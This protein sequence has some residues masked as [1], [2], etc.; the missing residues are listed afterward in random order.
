[1]ADLD[2]KTTIPIIDARRTL[3]IGLGT[4]G[5][6]ACNQILE[7]L[8]WSYE[9][10]DNVPWLRCLILETAPISNEKLPMLHTYSD[11]LPLQIDKSAYY[12][13]IQNP[14]NFDARIGFSSWNIP[15]L[16]NTGD[17]II[18]GA[19]N[20]R[21]LGRLAMLYPNNYN[22]L[23]NHL[24]SSLAA[25]QQVEERA[26][27][28]KFSLGIGEQTR[29]TLNSALYVYVIGSL[30]GGTSSGGFI[31]LGYILQGL[32]GYNSDLRTTGIFLL[33]SLQETNSQWKGNTYAALTELNHF[34]S[35]KSRYSQQ[36]PDRSAP[37]QLP[38]GTRPYEYCYLVQA[39]GAG[40]EEYAR[41]VTTS[42]DYIH[43]D[44]IGGNANERDAARTNIS[45]L[46]VQRDTWGATQKYFT[47]GLS[48]IEFPFSKVMKACSIK[49]T[50]T[51]FLAL[52]GGEKLNQFD[53]QDVLTKT[54]LLNPDNLV[55]SL[56]QRND[57][58]LQEQI[59]KV[60]EAEINLTSLESSDLAG[61]QA[62]IAFLNDQETD[63]AH[64]DL[65]IG[66]VKRTITNNARGV[67][68]LLQTDISNLVTQS[69]I[70]INRSVPSLKSILDALSEKLENG[71]KT[72]EN[73]KEQQT[74]PILKE[75]AEGSFENAVQAEKSLFFRGRKVHDKLQE[76][77]ERRKEYYAG[78]LQRECAPKGA[79]IYRDVKRY[80]DRIISRINNT[81]CGLLHELDQILE[82]LEALFKRTNVM[83]EAD[84]SGAGR[85]IRG[86][87]L[88]DPLKTV[89]QEYDNCLRVEAQKETS[90]DIRDTEKQ[91]AG[92]TL[93]SWISIAVDSLLTDTVV[94]NRYDP[95]AGETKKLD[96]AGIMELVRPARSY[97]AELKTSTIID[98][99]IND[100]S[101]ETYLKQANEG[102]GLLL[103]MNIGHPRHT[104]HDNKSYKFIF[105]HTEDAHAGEFVEELTKAR[106]VD[107]NHDHLSRISDPHQ[108]LILRERGAF[109]LGIVDGLLEE[110]PSSWKDAYYDKTIPSF[111]SR[112]DIDVWNGWSRTE[113][114]VYAAQR[115]IFLMGAALHLAE[116]VSA[117]EY[118]FRYPPKGPADP[119]IVTF[120]N[121]LELVSRMIRS[122]DLRPALEKAVEDFSRHNGAPDVIQRLDVFIHESDGKFKEIERTLAAQD[123][124]SILFEYIRKDADLLEQFRGKYPDVAEIRCLNKDEEGRDAY[125]CYHCGKKLGYVADNLY[126]NEMQN[127]AMRRLRKCAYCSKEL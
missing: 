3:L 1:M 44:L 27:G 86:V 72:F 69:L 115:S 48:S 87:E 78:K 121:D 65:P 25:L 125:F 94:I 71:I 19:N 89:D 116:F 20:V 109:S 84:R 47:F 5:A 111:H 52:R 76:C 120:P 12:N 85:V 80:L 35:D 81:N 106:I 83:Q 59:E 49:L 51:G 16:T 30:C 127:G 40:L 11:I 15:Q 2:T 100:A 70:N 75:S 92:K 99:I 45:S 21:I 46:L 7:R 112:G 67:N 33:P 126:L 36:F 107:R 34:S 95:D 58:N 118:I 103:K 79:E 18:D 6:R 39:Q 74:L 56:L 54:P 64:P 96:E 41:L 37:F 110:Q 28:D 26:A 60:L 63:R 22:E 114:E 57:S 8:Y 123:I 97:F 124:E 14:A 23:T 104:L 24:R 10:P 82:D 4:T 13:L 90:Q 122:L 53:I 102:S 61:I 43:T 73:I 68:S 117:Q 9:S 50:Q 42:A 17:A 91:L 66:I 93:Q 32:E 31:D 119:G 105:Y 55:R 113:E 77:L 62:D 88:F 38:P 101:L 108:I 29:V 98:R